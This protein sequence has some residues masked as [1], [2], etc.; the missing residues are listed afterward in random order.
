MLLPEPEDVPAA[1]RSFVDRISALDPTGPPRGTLTV[2]LG[3]REERIELRGPAAHALIEAL[4]QY[5]D[6]RDR[7]GCDHCGSHR[8]DDNFL[9]HDCG[10]PSGVFGQIL[11]ERA[12]DHTPPPELPAQ[13]AAASGRHARVE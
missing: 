13:P 6:P 12:H 5:H 11:M 4:R 3:D 2:T 7:G 10:R 8:L 1:V 9:C